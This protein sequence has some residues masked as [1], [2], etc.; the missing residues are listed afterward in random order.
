[1]VD[2]VGTAVDLGG[3]ELPLAE[4]PTST[5]AA[6]RH[7]SPVDSRPKCISRPYPVRSGDGRQGGSRWWTMTVAAM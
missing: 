4:H 6:T 5:P 7:S 2:V 1:V 3:A